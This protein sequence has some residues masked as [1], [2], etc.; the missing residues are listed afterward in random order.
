MSGGKETGKGF[1]RSGRSLLHL[2]RGGEGP[3]VGNRGEGG[4]EK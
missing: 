2:V 1:L 4:R 3:M